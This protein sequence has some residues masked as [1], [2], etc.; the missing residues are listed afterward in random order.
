MPGARET[1]QRSSM[2]DKKEMILLPSLEVYIKLAIPPLQ[3]KTA[4]VVD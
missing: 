1:L 3:R 2:S 4:G